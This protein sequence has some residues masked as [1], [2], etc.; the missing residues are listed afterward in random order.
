LVAQSKKFESILH[1]LKTGVNQVKPIIKVNPGNYFWR[2]MATNK[3]NKASEFS[4]INSFEIK[5]LDK[6]ELMF[7]Q[8]KNSFNL[9]KDSITFSW[10]KNDFSSNFIFEISPDQ[11]F[12]KKLRFHSDHPHIPRLHFVFE[13]H[14]SL[15]L[16]HP[17]P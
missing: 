10:K 15:L 9:E 12:Q 16:K 8:D 11:T 2:V 7:P 13:V 1:E 6:L 14:E 3:D 17:L 4:D 5:E